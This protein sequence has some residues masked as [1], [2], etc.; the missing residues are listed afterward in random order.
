MAA[1]A[2][3]TGTSVVVKAVVPGW[4]S[5]PRRVSFPDQDSV[6]NRDDDNDLIEL[7]TAADLNECLDFFSFGGSN[8]SSLPLELGSGSGK[9]AVTLRLEIL[10]EYDGPALSE[11]GTGTG[12]SSGDRGLSFSSY[13]GPAGAAPT[14]SRSREGT[15]ISTAATDR[16]GALARWKAEQDALA[17]QFART[18]VGRRTR[19]EQASPIDEEALRH[20]RNGYENGWQSHWRRSSG[21]AGQDPSRAAPVSTGELAQARAR[22][23]PAR[24]DALSSDE[25]WVQTWAYDL[26]GG[27]GT[28]D[29]G[30]SD[31]RSET[32]RDDHLRSDGDAHPAGDGA[33]D[34]DDGWDLETVSSVPFGV[35][36]RLPGRTDRPTGVTAPPRR[37]DHLHPNFASHFIAAPEQA[38]AATFG[39]ALA[40]IRAGIVP[41]PT[42]TSPTGRSPPPQPVYTSFS[43]MFSSPTASSVYS[44]APDSR[45]GSDG[46]DGARADST[47]RPTGS[48]RARVE[49]LFAPSE[50]GSSTYVNLAELEG[51]DGPARAREGGAVVMNGGEGGNTPPAAASKAR[52]PLTQEAQEDAV[53]CAVCMDVIEGTKYVCVQ[54][55]GYHLC[56]TCETD[57]SAKLASRSKRATALASIGWGRRPHEYIPMLHD[58]NHVLLKIRPG[59]TLPAASRLA[60]LSSLHP[61]RALPAGSS[62][63][64]PTAPPMAPPPP[65]VRPPSAPLP[66]TGRTQPIE[67]RL[68]GDGPTRLTIPDRL[69]SERREREGPAPPLVPPIEI[70]AFSIPAISAPA[71]N[72]NIPAVEIPAVNIP[73]VEM[74]PVLQGLNQAGGAARSASNAFPYEPPSFKRFDSCST[75]ERDSDQIHDPSHAFLRLT[76][77]LQRPLPSLSSGLVPLLYLPPAERSVATGQEDAERAD[78]KGPK[79]TPPAGKQIVCDACGNFITA[80]W[81]MC[82]HCPASFDLCRPCLVDRNASELAR[83]NPSHVFLEL[84]DSQSVDL[85]LLKEV[86]RYTSRRP[87]GLLEWDLYA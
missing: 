84:K 61:A 16:E 57:P 38:G 19:P 78:G 62:A 72:L 85:A 5:H 9:M 24:G 83:H 66:Y 53:T 60:L 33:D 54:C 51:G 18:A 30:G 44:Y 21:A 65:P 26:T 81:M 77:R 59:A 20:E 87:R 43:P 63:A 12:F 45:Y 27:N 6:S 56:E 67:V 17:A 71:I 46:V 34:D 75:C 31:L 50:V 14:P 41:P 76:H 64:T 80:E 48:E 32:P 13:P 7:A 55:E 73:A 68:P 42:G 23:L 74:P 25:E 69:A 22:L 47:Y 70:P 2:Q 10:V 3:R 8:T 36:Q 52:D 82:C 35:D 15:T 58:A 4:Q 11:A 39:A 1:T 49:A 86:T 37:V 79:G 40:G 28:D 29:G